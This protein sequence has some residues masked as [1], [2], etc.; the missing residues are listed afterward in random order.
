MA[1]TITPLDKH[2]KVRI[3]RSGSANDMVIGRA[4]ASV[5]MDGFVTIHMP[6][7]PYVIRVPID[8]IDMMGRLDG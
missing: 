5:S 1:L 2:G 6:I 3:E 4:K 8:W 7:E